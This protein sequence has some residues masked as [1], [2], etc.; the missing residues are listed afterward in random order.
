MS[1]GDRLPINELS[2]YLRGAG[3]QQRAENPGHHEGA[4]FEVIGNNILVYPGEAASTRPGIAPLRI[5]VD[6]QGRI[7]SMTNVTTSGRLSSAAIKGRLLV[8][9]REGDRRKAIPVQFSDIPENI[10]NAIVAAEDRRFFSHSGIDWRGI[11][12][13][14]K[15]D[16]NEGE[17]VQGGSTITQ[18]IIRTVF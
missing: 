4:T 16:L 2:D 8:S 3:Y 5:Q 18:Q 13:A 12:R 1:V 6:K 9:V 7:A 14:L 11:M 10:R 17:F 15:T